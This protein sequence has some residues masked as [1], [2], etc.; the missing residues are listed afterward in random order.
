MQPRKFWTTS[1]SLHYCALPTVSTYRAY[2]HLLTLSS[3]STYLP[4]VP[5][6]CRERVSYVQYITVGVQRYILLPS[7]GS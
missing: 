5:T 4:T 3:L 1:S 2:L 6:Y 7:L